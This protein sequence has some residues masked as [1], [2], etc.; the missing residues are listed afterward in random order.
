M[1]SKLHSCVFEYGK[2]CTESLARF[3][4]RVAGSH[5]FLSKNDQPILDPDL[6]S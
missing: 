3:D 6:V 4:W 2:K 1:R 5:S